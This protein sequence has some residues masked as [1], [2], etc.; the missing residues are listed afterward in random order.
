[1]T[2]RFAAVVQA[3]GR[4]PM[5]S[6]LICMQYDGE[7]GGARRQFHSMRVFRTNH[8]CG[9]ANAFSTPGQ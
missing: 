3:A 1:M 6:A 8:P 9:G 2:L 7:S 4:P 5:R